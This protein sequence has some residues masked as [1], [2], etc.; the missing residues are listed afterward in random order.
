MLHIPHE[1]HHVAALAYLGDT[2]RRYT[3]AQY[4][5]L[6]AQW[7]LIAAIY[8]R[9]LGVDPDCAVRQAE[10]YEATVHF[11]N[12]EITPAQARAAVA[13]A[14]AGTT[15]YLAAYTAALH[16]AICLCAP[17]D[18]AR[19]MCTVQAAEACGVHPHHV[20]Q[21]VRRILPSGGV[22]PV[23]QYDEPVTVELPIVQ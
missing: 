19:P 10:A 3:D 20:E 12:G 16:V 5:W 15:Q 7:E 11:L 21:A 1:D 23:G 8:D 13:D 2:P 6:A 17:P 14:P 4:G 9:H 22:Y 18:T